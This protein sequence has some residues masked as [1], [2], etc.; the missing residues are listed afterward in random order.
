MRILVTGNRPAVADL[1]RLL[2]EF[3]Y[4]VVT[5]SGFE[6]ALPAW[7]HGDCEAALISIAS[8]DPQ[9][10]AVVTA[11]R[12][13]RPHAPIVI[14][15]EMALLED[16]VYMNGGQRGLQVKLDPSKA[17]SVLEAKR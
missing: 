2:L 13:R 7:S 10:F 9:P 8:S 5:H 6:T 12:E 17:A 16:R 11:F 14:V 3:G 4:E 1:G 15:S